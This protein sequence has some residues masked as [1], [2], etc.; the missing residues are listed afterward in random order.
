MRKASHVQYDIEYHIVWTTK[1]RY[2]V[3][4]GDIALRAREIIRRCCSSLNVIRDFSKIKVN[5]FS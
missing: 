3:L 4:T 1:Y 2:R 5:I